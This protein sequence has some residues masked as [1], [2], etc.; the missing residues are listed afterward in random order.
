KPGM[1]AWVALEFGPDLTPGKKVFVSAAT[2]GVGLIVGQLAKMRG[3]HVVGS[4]GKNKEKDLLKDYFK[5]DEAFN[6]EVGDNY[7][8]PLKSYFP[9]GIDIY[10]DNFGVSRML[11]S[12]LNL[13]KDHAR[14][15]ICG[16]TC[17]YNNK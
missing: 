17:Q 3:C 15:V 9:E 5:F 4:V 10:F 13:I 6:H 12:V 14:I 2:G 11:D 7:D 8:E 1:T 16:M